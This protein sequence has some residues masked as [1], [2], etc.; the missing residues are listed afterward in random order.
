MQDACV[1]TGFSR[2][3]FTP[4]E[5]ARLCALVAECGPGDWS[6]IALMM[7]HRDSRQCKERWSHY[8]SPNLVNRPWTKTEDALLEAEVREHG[9]KWKA[10][11]ALFPGRAETNIKN[12]FNVLFRRRQKQMQ[13][14]MKNARASTQL[15]ESPPT[16]SPTDSSDTWNEAEFEF[17]FT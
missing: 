1:G 12:R 14:I 15:P 6:R 10:F 7:P 13:F 4:D 2:H 5:D 9:H 8:L 17:W 3:K 11:E 16:A